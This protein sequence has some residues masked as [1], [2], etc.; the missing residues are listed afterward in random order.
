MTVVV[1]DVV[2]LVL[3]TVVEV[4]KTVWAMA[5]AKM[6]VVWNATKKIF[7]ENIIRNQAILRIK[8]Q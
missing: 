2:R 5:N 7:V 4:D 3:G 6:A 8:P 1:S